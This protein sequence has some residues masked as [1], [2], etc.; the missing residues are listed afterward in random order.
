MGKENQAARANELLMK[1]FGSDITLKVIFFL[2][3]LGEAELSET[4]IWQDEDIESE[5]YYTDID[6]C[7]NS[8]KE[9]LTAKHRKIEHYLG[10]FKQVKQ[11][12]YTDYI[13]NDVELCSFFDATAPFLTITEAVKLYAQLRCE[14]D[15]DKT[16]RFAQGA[17]IDLMD[18]AVLPATDV[19]QLMSSQPD[20]HVTSKNYT[21]YVNLLL[22]DISMGDFIRLSDIVTALCDLLP[23]ENELVQEATAVVDNVGNTLA[24]FKTGNVCPRCGLPLYLSDLPQYDE[25]CF[26][27]DENF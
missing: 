17:V 7:Y 20:T 22:S 14:I 3:D 21:K 6:E 1:E 10:S 2:A 25:A 24:T 15:G 11:L 5:P 8:A 26:E 19:V 12:V 4:F 27:C 9:Y 13:K 16:I 23:A 18:D